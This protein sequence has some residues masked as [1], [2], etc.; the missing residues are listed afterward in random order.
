MTD[1]SHFSIA[2]P[3]IAGSRSSAQI[4]A[5]AVDLRRALEIL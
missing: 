1:P 4:A 3:D 2:V 5:G